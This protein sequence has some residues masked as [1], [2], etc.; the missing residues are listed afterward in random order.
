VH[1]LT[2]AAAP[3][4]WH[5]EHRDA[6]FG[7][8]ETDAA[9]APFTAEPAVSAMTVL[10]QAIT[11]MHTL[12]DGDDDKERRRRFIQ[13]A[14]DATL[15]YHLVAAPGG[16]GLKADAIAQNSSLATRLHVDGEARKYVG[17]LLAGEPFRVRAGK[18]LLPRP[19]VY[20]N[21]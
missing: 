14:I 16:E 8:L 17:D 19:G 18:S 4:N 10:E 2:P 11:A 1:A 6:A 15:R 13:K 7:T 9:A 12:A 21:L 20:F 5:R 3:V